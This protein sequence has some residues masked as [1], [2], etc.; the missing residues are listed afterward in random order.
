MEHWSRFFHYARRVRVISC[1]WSWPTVA[2]LLTLFTFRPDTGVPLFPGLHTV[3]YRTFDDQP[4]NL[5]PVKL[6]A[7]PGLHTLRLC[8]RWQSGSGRDLVFLQKLAPRL[9]IFDGSYS[10]WMTGPISLVLPK[11]NHLTM[12]HCSEVRSTPAGLW[13][14]GQLPKLRSL[15]I[16]VDARISSP[17]TGRKVLFPALQ[18]LSVTTSE[19]YVDL[20][21][22]LQLV[23]SRRLRTFCWL[24]CHGEASSDTTLRQCLL[25]LA[26]QPLLSRLD[27]RGDYCRNT[28]IPARNVSQKVRRCRIR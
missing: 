27:I 26:Q 2:F 22:L 18:S 21:R 28:I 10:A 3:I 24:I 17:P 13:F 16:Y 7:H 9:Q 11:W 5:L 25:L 14:L 8:C 4:V 20:A 1:A 19:P 6:L 23:A 15:D 12:F